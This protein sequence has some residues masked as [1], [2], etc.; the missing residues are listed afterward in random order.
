MQ[1]TIIHSVGLLHLRVVF[2]YLTIML[3][4]RLFFQL[5]SAYYPSLYHLGLYLHLP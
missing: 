2:V 1:G 4:A 5:S 3:V